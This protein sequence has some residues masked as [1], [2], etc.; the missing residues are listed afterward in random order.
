MSR[1]AEIWTGTAIPAFLS[2]MGDDA[3]LTHAGEDVACKAIFES[4]L[5]AVG[6]YGERMENRHTAQLANSLGAVIGDTLTLP[7]PDPMDDDV[8]WR[9]TQ[10]LANDG[11]MTRF[12]IRRE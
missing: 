3:V 2:M 5:T 10:T 1:F 9:L 7:A 12:A 6:D 4:G 8:V 11:F